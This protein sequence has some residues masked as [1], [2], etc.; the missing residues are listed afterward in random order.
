V[1]GTVAPGAVLRF[2]STSRLCSNS[3]KVGDRFTGTLASAVPASNGFA[4]PAGATGTF[5]VTG[6]RTAR[7]QN[8]E[9]YLRLRLMQIAYAG[10][11]YVVDAGLVSGAME[12]VRSASSA[13]DAAKVAGGALIGAVAGQVL[14]RGTKGTVIGAAA[15]AAA[16]TAAAAKSADYDTCIAAGAPL[17]AALTATLVIQPAPIP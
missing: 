1:T 12:R 6:V 14:G 7:N 15:G 11:S 3:A 10:R 2:T 9:T 17:T 13:Q 8:E 4:I 16:G 5:E